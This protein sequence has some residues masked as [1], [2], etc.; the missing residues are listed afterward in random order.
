[1][2]VA[3]E[4]RLADYRQFLADILRY[5]PHTLSAAEEKIAA[6]AGAGGTAGGHA[7][8]PRPPIR[9][10]DGGRVRPDPQAYTK[11]R[12]STKRADRDSVFRAFWQAHQDFRGMLGAA[13][14][15]EL[16]AH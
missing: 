5:A 2:Y 14:N 12:A 6:R 13:L 15:A 11:Y 9:L 1:A 4:P 8:P 16:K 7:A 10:P 3:A